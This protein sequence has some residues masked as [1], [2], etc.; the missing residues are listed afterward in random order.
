[1]RMTMVLSQR[2][3]MPPLPRPRSLDLPHHLVATVSGKSPRC[4]ISHQSIRES[5]GTQKSFMV[6][7]LI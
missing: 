7:Y 6:D 3:L 4:P 1:M 2:Y 5:S